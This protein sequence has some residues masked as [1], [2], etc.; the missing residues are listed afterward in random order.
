MNDYHKVNMFLVVLKLDQILA[1]TEMETV[2]RG[3]QQVTPDTLD[4]YITWKGT[5]IFALVC[6][7][8]ELYIF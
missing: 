5:N 6:L 7:Y 4:T 3:S 1:P 2:L 8:Y